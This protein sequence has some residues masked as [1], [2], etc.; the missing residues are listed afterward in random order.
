MT[1]L[2]CTSVAVVP[3]TFTPANAF[4][5]SVA[6]FARW[7]VNNPKANSTAMARAMGR[8]RVRVGR[9]DALNDVATVAPPSPRPASVNHSRRGAHGARA[10]T[11]AT[12]KSESRQALGQRPMRWKS[13]SARASLPGV[14]PLSKIAVL[15]STDEVEKPKTA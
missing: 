4:F 11:P 5:V 10:D 14:P 8:M 15:T 9:G 6:L 7:A 12:P 3:T 2:G 1:W 13:E